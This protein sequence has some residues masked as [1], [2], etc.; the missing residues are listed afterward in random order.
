MLPARRVCAIIAVALFA[1]LSHAANP[2]PLIKR[3]DIASTTSLSLPIAGDKDKT[4]KERAGIAASFRDVDARLYGYTDAISFT[5]SKSLIDA[6]NFPVWGVGVNFNNLLGIP[7]YVQTGTLITGGSLS[8]LHSPEL[9]INRLSLFSSSF[10]LPKGVETSLPA[11]SSSKKNIA[12]SFLSKVETGMFTTRVCAIA[13]EDGMASSSLQ[14]VAALPR[15]MEAGVCVT[16]GFF[17]IE[18]KNAHSSSA[19]WYA[20]APYFNDSKIAS[21]CFQTYFDSQYAACILTGNIYEQ[22]ERDAAV[23]GRAEAAFHGEVFSL[24]TG[25]FAVNKALSIDTEG[26]YI[27][28]TFQLMA[29]PLITLHPSGKHIN[30]LSFGAL[31]FLQRYDD[32]GS[33]GTLNEYTVINAATGVRYTDSRISCQATFAVNNIPLTGDGGNDD[34]T[35][36]TAVQGSVKSKKI[37]HTARASASFSPDTDGR[38]VSAGYSITAA[39]KKERITG[40]A[41]LTFERTKGGTDT[42]TA[43]ISAKAAMTRRPF[44]ITIKAAIESRVMEL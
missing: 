2:P 19:S 17:P 27:K 25:L 30:T 11:L 4:I 42:I 6:I 31:A 26:D 44:R 3:I 23:T 20:P 15:M 16:G 5:K 38:T 24:R 8:R 22:P 36:E 41:K 28:K 14:L 32:K 12:S 13:D 37:K 7:L 10:S 1:Q 33:K 21:S 43:S 40:D 35:Y 29:Q 39:A 34:V 18:D 9:S